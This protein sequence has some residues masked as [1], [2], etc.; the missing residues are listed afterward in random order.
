MRHH[1]HS[2]LD[3][4]RADLL[5]R[6]HVFR[7][8]IDIAVEFDFFLGPQLRTSVII[9]DVDPFNRFRYGLRNPQSIPRMIDDHKD[10]HRQCL[11]VG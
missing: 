11:G 3:R 1:L 7:I 4:Q 5:Q 9:P 6:I 8:E 10:F 2:K